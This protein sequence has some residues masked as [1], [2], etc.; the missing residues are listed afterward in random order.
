GI[1]VLERFFQGFTIPLRLRDLI[2]DDAGLPE[3]CQLAIQDACVLTNPRPV[4]WEGCLQIC[5]DVW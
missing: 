2:S 3:V 1:E 5:E 4:T